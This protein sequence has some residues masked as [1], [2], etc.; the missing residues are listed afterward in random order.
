MD[1][2]VFHCLLRKLSD[3]ENFLECLMVVLEKCRRKDQMGLIHY[4]VLFQVS[5]GYNTSEINWGTWTQNWVKEVVDVAQ[6]IY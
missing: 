1:A 6:N 3:K 4:S 5:H 2:N